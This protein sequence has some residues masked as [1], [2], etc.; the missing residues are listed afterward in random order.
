MKKT[1]RTKS[2]KEPVRKFRIYIS[3]RTS[4]Q[5][6]DVLIH[7]TYK[8]LQ[9][10]RE[11]KNG[12]CEACFRPDNCDRIA[13]FVNHHEH[14]H[15]NPRIG[16]L[17]FYPRSLTVGIVTHELFHAVTCWAKNMGCVPGWD[18]E[19]A[20]NSLTKGKQDNEEVC[21]EVIGNLAAQFF[22]AL[23][24]IGKVLRFDK[25]IEIKYVE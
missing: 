2:T 20:K 7:P 4:P 6:L 21:A 18:H 17:N 15:G 25:S 14:N 16:T 23:A 5:Y 24:G 8:A 10:Y 19:P 11:T 3:P 1:K 13:T 22:V 9:R 12:G